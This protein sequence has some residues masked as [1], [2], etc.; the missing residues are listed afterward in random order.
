VDVVGQSPA[1]TVSGDAIGPPIIMKSSD[2]A[3]SRVMTFFLTTVSD[4]RNLHLDKEA[5]EMARRGL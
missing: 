5:Q 4:M 2:R 1:K 3:R